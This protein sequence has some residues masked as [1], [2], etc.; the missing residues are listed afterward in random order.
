M[1]GKIKIIQKAINH[2]TAI[3]RRK[4]ILARISII[5]A[6]RWSKRGNGYA[7]RFKGVRHGMD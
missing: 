6:E 2:I 1:S 4:L 5:E 3:E 7:A